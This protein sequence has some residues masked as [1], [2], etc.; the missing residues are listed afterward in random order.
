MSPLF[1]MIGWWKIQELRKKCDFTTRRKWNVIERSKRVLID[2]IKSQIFIKGLIVC[3]ILY[4]RKLT[5]DSC[6]I[7]LPFGRMF[8]LG[9]TTWDSITQKH[10]YNNLP[11]SS[12]IFRFQENKMLLKLFGLN[13]HSVLFSLPLRVY[14][15]IFMTAK[16]KLETLGPHLEAYT[17]SP[18][19]QEATTSRSLSICQASLIYTAN[20]RPA[21][22]T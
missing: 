4:L 2:W 5:P 17:F 6:W 11:Y 19:N 13:H 7:F 16:L 10:T 14:T 18:S 22:A 21:S 12:R 15:S 3:L 9:Y 8:A 20:F 1:P